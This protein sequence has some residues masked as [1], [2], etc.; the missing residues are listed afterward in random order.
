MQRIPF[1]NKDDLARVEKQLVEA[2]QKGNVVVVPTDTSYGMA[3]DATNAGAINRVYDIKD[4]DRKKPF[5]IIVSDIEMAN[6]YAYIT[7]FSKK[8]IEHFLP[9]PISFLILQKIGALPYDLTHGSDLVGIRIPNNSLLLELVRLFGTPVTATSANISGEPD[10]YDPA[11]IIETFEDAKLDPDFL[12]DGGVLPPVQPSTMISVGA[13]NS[14]SLVRQGPISFEEVQQ[15]A[16][17]VSES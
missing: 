15:F 5:H 7:N 14:L 6:D 9:G 11:N 2:W 13:D 1:F 17:T 4:R 10:M 8:L 3:V 16:K 12:L